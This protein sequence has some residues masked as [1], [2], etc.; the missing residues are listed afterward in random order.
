LKTHV[1]R[2]TV[3]VLLAVAAVVAYAVDVSAAVG[4]RVLLR[5]L[6]VD[7]GT[8][9]PTALAAQMDR[10]AIP[11]T[12][13]II[14]SSGRQVISAAFLADAATGTGRFQ[15]VLL[16]NANGGG[17][18]SSELTALATYERDYGV[19]QVNG[20]DWPGGAL[21]FANPAFSGWA[22]GG[23][24][25]ITA[26]GA[27][28]GFGYLNGSVP[29]DDF[30]AAGEVY[31]YFGVPAA[32]QPAG[33]TVTPLVTGSKG[34][35]SGS[36]LAVVNTSGREQ[37]VI[38]AAFDQYMQSFNALAPGILSWAT[39]GIHLGYQ[40]SYFSAHIDD[41]LMPDSRW[42]TQANC[43]PGDDCTDPSLTTPDIRMTAADVSRLVAW[44]DANGVV[45]DMVF[46]AGGSDAA[47]AENNGTD[48]LT[49]ALLAQKSRFRWINHTYSHPYLGCI[50]IA[51]TL[52]GQSW[53]CATSATDFPRFDSEVEGAMSGSTYWA[54]QAYVASQV[55]RN[56]Q[57]AQTN[58]LPGYR[59]RELVTG[60]HSGLASLPQMTSD[61]PFLAP[62][63]AGAGVRY[64]ASDASREPDSRLLAG[65]TTATLPRH[66]M[67]VYYNTATYAEAVDEYNWYYTSKANGGSG[68]C[69]NNALS[70]C[71]TPLAAGTPAQAEASFKS[72]ILPL[73]VR[74]LVRYM[75]TN[76]PRPVYVHQS[77][78]A[79]DGLLYPVLEAALRTYRSVYNTSKA[80][81]VQTGMTELTT[82]L[83]RVRS[84]AA[85]S[86][87]VQAYVD[88]RG[89]H[90][91]AS[92]VAVPLTVPAG[93][94]GADLA[95]YAGEMSGWSTSARTVTLPTPGGGYLLN[96]AIERPAAP[97]IGSVTPGSTTATVTWTPPADNGGSAITGYT[98]SVFPGT[99]TTPSTTVP[100]AAGATS[101]KVT[102]LTN[103]TAYRFT[104]AAINAAGAGAA[105]ALSA[106]VTP[107][108][109][110]GGIP[111]GVSAQAGNGS[112]RVTWTAP[113]VTDGITAYRVRAFNGTSTT[114]TRTVTVG[115]TATSAAVLSLANG[116]G[117]TVDVTGMWGTS[118]G[119][120]SARSASVAPALS[121]QTV[122]A[123][124]VGSVVPANRSIT[125]TWTPPADTSLGT[126]AGYRVQLFL[127]SA[128]TSVNRTV[129]V[130]GTARTATLTSLSN[131]TAYSAQVNA[132]Y[133]SG[134]GASS[135]RTAVVIPTGTAPTAPVVGTASPGTAGG[136]ITATAR[137]SAP[138]STGGSA[139]TGYRVTAY[140]L[141]ANGSVLGTTT[142]P[143]L[144]A[145]LQA[146][147]MILPA[148]GSY[149]FTVVAINAYGTS[150]AS[151]RS[152]TVAGR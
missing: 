103:N 18:A 47:K 111:T 135:A 139:I 89:V 119:T 24:A 114:A 54:S 75:M 74:Q 64:T 145:S 43:T 10:E 26:A 31:A 9:G 128:G 136:A 61:N 109:T 131:G 120:A 11:Y 59:V 106:W 85:V 95:T 20:Y 76:D 134:D 45:L 82:G 33:Q 81:L 3:T 60:E 7:D 25:Q 96:Q 68:I 132:V 102:G 118:P 70:T 147:A 77:N 44:Q 144:S 27:S 73:E 2:F 65:G 8:A 105:S 152:N 140:R 34:G 133:A 13:I 148:T 93:S 125:I 51:P 6:L 66:P 40:R 37:L 30:A 124:V 46:N 110:L 21:G 98:I 86:S 62:A 48:A 4:Q 79:E 137:W 107:R 130:A 35:A 42:S 23:T 91:P 29:I 115:A 127:G 36:L 121:A 71:I 53:R 78:L 101:L 150:P 149:S 55:T 146:Y 19:R 16:P 63:L 84:F 39:R 113:S 41:V 38:S 151:A 129:Q 12:K 90:V 67:N 138:T 22:D 17:L 14:G 112:L 57:W 94:T 69:E 116:T 15:A 5:V 58:S 126:P 56:S 141:A 117:Y 80:P 32:T 104:V 50:Q 72:Y 28:D 83:Q 108:V 52:A 88:S 87:G 97:T 123:P 1:A 99:A 92:A 49:T 122:N 100:A 143:T 142:S